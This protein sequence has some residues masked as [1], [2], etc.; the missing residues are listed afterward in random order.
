MWNIKSPP[1][2]Y[3]ITKNRWLWKLKEK[4][5]DFSNDSRIKSEFLSLAELTPR[6]RRMKIGRRI[7]RN[8]NLKS[9]KARQ[10]FVVTRS[11]S[12]FDS[13]AKIR[14]DFIYRIVLFYLIAFI[15]YSSYTGCPASKRWHSLSHKACIDLGEKL[16]R[17]LCLHCRF[18]RILSD[19]TD[20][21]KV[22]G[23]TTGCGVPCSRRT[24]KHSVSG[25]HLLSIAYK[26]QL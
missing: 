2:K 15:L 5:C 9:C 22:S 17:K 6:A 21:F 10:Y 12:V 8:R 7:A 14:R 23:L 3:S 20:W 1:F 13:G 24:F 16:A 19:S 26:Y 4:C 18:H 25:N 11:S